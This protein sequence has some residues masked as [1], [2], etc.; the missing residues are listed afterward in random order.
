MLDRSLMQ[1]ENTRISSL[2]L[3]NLYYLPLSCLTSDVVALSLLF[4][5]KFLFV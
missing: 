4:Y 3:A 5:L 1:V 2:M